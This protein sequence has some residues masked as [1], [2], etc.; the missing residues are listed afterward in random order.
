[1]SQFKY[2]SLD[3]VENDSDN[4]ENENKFPGMSSP[5]NSKQHAVQKSPNAIDNQ[6]KLYPHKGMEI[7]DL[8]EFLRR[9]GDPL[10]VE[11]HLHEGFWAA[12]T[13]STRWIVKL[14]PRSRL[15]DPWSKGTRVRVD[16]VSGGRRQPGFLIGHITKVST[17]ELVIEGLLEENCECNRSRSTSFRGGAGRSSAGRS[18]SSPFFARM[19]KCSFGRKESS[20]TDSEPDN[21]AGGGDDF[22]GCSHTPEHRYSELVNAGAARSMPHATTLGS[23]H[24]YGNE[25]SPIENYKKYN[26]RLTLGVDVSEH[27][28]RSGYMLVGTLELQERPAAA[29]ARRVSHSGSVRKLQQQQSVM[30]SSLRSKREST[31]DALST[32]TGATAEYPL[33]SLTWQI[34]HF[35]GVKRRQFTA[36]LTYATSPSV[37]RFLEHM[38]QTGGNAVCQTVSEIQRNFGDFAKQLAFPNNLYTQDL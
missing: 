23:I 36:N 17:R 2:H 21:A 24:T 18:R 15:F 25:N 26:F 11:L 20:D 12:P 37:E 30:S 6:Y 28:S 35:A 8:L 29:D 9:E 27:D 38:S 1:M 13:L 16:Q 5:S 32:A 19:F 10:S 33:R 31:A 34:T 22:V 3:R 7:S 14:Q 4:D